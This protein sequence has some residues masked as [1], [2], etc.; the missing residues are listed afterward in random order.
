MESSIS[1][2]FDNLV[3]RLARVQELKTGPISG[4]VNLFPESWVNFFFGGNGRRLDETRPVIRA[5]SSGYELGQIT[6]MSFFPREWYTEAQLASIDHSD[7][8]SKKV[9]NDTS[10][11]MKLSRHLGGPYE[12]HPTDMLRVLYDGI[13]KEM[14]RRYGLEF[15]KPIL[16]DARLPKS[17]IEHDV[18]ENYVT[19]RKKIDELKKG[20]EQQEEIA[21]IKRDINQIVAQIR[22][23]RARV[24][25]G[26]YDDKIRFVAEY[27]SSKNLDEAER[28]RML[29][30]SIGSL[31]VIDW[32]TR[33]NE[34]KL[35]HDS[36]FGLHRMY[37]LKNYRKRSI[38]GPIQVDVMTHFGIS[39]AELEPADYY[40][41]RVLAKSIDRV[42][43]SME[44]K[45]RFSDSKARDLDRLMKKNHYLVDTYGKVRFR[46]KPEWRA[47]GLSLLFKNAIVLQNHGIGL[48]DYGKQIVDQRSVNPLSHLY[49]LA[50]II[51]T[52]MLLEEYGRIVDQLILSYKRSLSRESAEAV[53]K[54]V[55]KKPDSWFEE[56]TGDGPI[57]RGIELDK[58]GTRWRDLDKSEVERAKNYRDVLAFGQLL[59]RFKSPQKNLI[60]PENGVFSPFIIK[61]LRDRVNYASYPRPTR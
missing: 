35:F 15:V 17:I 13:F 11:E 54:E 58:P 56:Y 7:I 30:E 21:G 38:G 39:P 42:A 37:S 12:A 27:A 61:G 33:H 26:L 18:L 48:K 20:W 31:G 40:G 50:G 14:I 51:G 49:L 46:A 19:I 22:D 52:E 59:D 43:L 2:R 44:R 29:L 53:E 60:D 25:R 41:A 47:Y 4:I 34:R 3:M 10:S 24:V 8:V 32:L 9:H 16:E 57:S 1:A 28:K 23:E 5:A 6:R 36:M 45:P 55:S